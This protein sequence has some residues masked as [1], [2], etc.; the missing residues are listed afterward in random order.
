MTDTLD[1]EWWRDYR[2][3]LEKRFVQDELV[4]RSQTVERL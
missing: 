3:T 4:I 2:R 1:R